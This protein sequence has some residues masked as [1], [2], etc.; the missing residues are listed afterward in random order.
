M[1]LSAEALWVS[2]PEWAAVLTEE[3]VVG[4]RTFLLSFTCDGV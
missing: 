3:Q 1:P 2:Q 4:T